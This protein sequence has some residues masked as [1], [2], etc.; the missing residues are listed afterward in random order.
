MTIMYKLTNECHIV[1]AVGSQNMID[2]VMFD[3]LSI[4]IHVSL[5]RNEIPWQQHLFLSLSLS[6]SL[7]TFLCSQYQLNY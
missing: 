7:N 4:F 5:L 1:S 6:L 3:T 2:S